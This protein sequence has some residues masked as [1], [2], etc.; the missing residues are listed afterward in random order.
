[1]SSTP[2]HRAFC[3]RGGSYGCWAHTFRM[4][5]AKAAVASQWLAAVLV[6]SG[7]IWRCSSFC[8]R[9]TL[10]A[11]FGSPASFAACLADRVK[12]SCV[13]ATQQPV[14][15][16]FRAV[17]LLVR[18]LCSGMLSWMRWL[19]H[20]THI[21]G[22]TFAHNAGVQPLTLR[23]CVNNFQEFVHISHAPLILC[24]SNFRSGLSLGIE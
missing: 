20:S 17:L 13:H 2:A 7:K 5:R 4:P 21:H 15:R 6:C 1:M 19:C 24:Q 18:L 3:G 23:F 10:A 11:S 9:S 22:V 14:E 8:S 12:V 16:L